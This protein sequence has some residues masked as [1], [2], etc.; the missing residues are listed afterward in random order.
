M[1]RTTNL[2]RRGATYYFRIAVP[3][4][5]R[6]KVGR[7]ELWR[8]LRTRDPGEAR[9]R[10]VASATAAH[11]L[12]D[13]LRSLPMLTR[14]QIDALIRRYFETRL[15]MDEEFRLDDRPRPFDWRADPW[16]RLHLSQIGDTEEEID[17]EIRARGRHALDIAYDEMLAHDESELPGMLRRKELD[18]AEKAADQLLERHGVT[19]DRDSI[20]YRQLCLGILRADLEAVRI[21]IGRSQGDWG[22]QPRDRLF[23]GP[24]LASEPVMATHGA[25]PLPEKPI[26]ETVARFLDEKTRS[27][28]GKKWVAEN[29]LALRMLQEFHPA[30]QSVSSFT[31]A[32]LVEFKDAVGKLPARYSLKFRNA[33]I[34]EA[35][36]LNKSARL[37]PRDPIST[38]L[39][40]LKPIQEFFDWAVRNGYRSDNPAEGVELTVAKKSAA[41]KK[42][43]AFTIDDLRKV[44]NAPVFRGARSSYYW[45]E[46]GPVRIRDYRFWLPLMGLFT[47]GRLRELGQL[48]V[49]DI[50]QRE[51][52]WMI[53]ITDIDDESG[54]KSV[55][56]THSRRLVPIHP[57]LIT[58]GLLEYRLLRKRAGKKGLFEE[59]AGARGDYGVASKWFGRLLDQ[60]GLRSS[61]LVFHSLRHTFESAMIENRVDPIIR[62][63]LTGRAIQGSVKHYV[64]EAGPQRMLE[65]ISKV[66]YPGLDLSHLYPTEGQGDS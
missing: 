46:P 58:I 39:K 54:S 18:L 20:E 27:G 41:K 21:M 7:A 37:P 49:D 12:F 57:E 19:L 43:D 64:T 62:S 48:G 14:S 22:V 33:T 17:A 40:C 56:N 3:A 31:K 51:G 16:A 60:V 13:L 53:N 65:E 4:A 59:A 6:T 66:R 52:V 15:E 36:E 10:A 25:R 61:R 8:S 32:D 38:N 2:F 42:R 47:G 45:S 50:L 11:R 24:P 55:K 29:R 63:W 5:L 23:V 26:A 28:V 30:R 35:L 44:F 9:R 34:R 1:A